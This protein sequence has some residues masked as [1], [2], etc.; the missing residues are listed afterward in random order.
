MSATPASGERAALRGYRWQYDHIAAR[1]YDALLDGDFKSLRLTDPDAGRVDDLVL[2]R[3][4]RADGY[5]FKSAAFNRYLTFRQ[6][7]TDQRT[8]SGNRAPSLLHSLADGWKGLQNQHGDTHVHLV[9]QD[10]ASITDHLGDTGS[11]DQPSPDHFSALITRVLEPL[12]QG[13]TTFG[14]I[15]KGWRPALTRLERASGLEREDFEQ[16]LRFLYLDT[17]AGPGIPLS[18]STRQS[19][20]VALSTALFRCVSEAAGVVVLEERDVLSLMGWLNRPRLHSRHEFP[21]NLDTYQPLAAAIEQL[22]ELTVRHHMGYVAVIGP[23]GSGK[24]TLLSQALTGTVD[25][26]VR[27][28]AYVPGTATAR[29]RLTATTFLHD[30]V[31][32]LNA[33]GLTASERRLPSEDVH[34]LRQQLADQL[35]AAGAEFLEK[36]HRTIIVV[37]GL[38]HVD[39]DYSGSDGLLAE[40]PGPDAI[41]DGVLF[42]VG[43][44]TLTPLHASVRQQIADR[45]ATVDLQHH[46]LSPASI[47]EIC[48]RA[49]VTA[50]LSAEIHQ[51]IVHLSAGHPLALSY[52]LN[53]LRDADGTSA[54]DE[55]ATAPAYEGDVAAQYRAVWD[56]IEDD[57]KIVNIL[58]VCSRLRIGFTTEWLASWASDSAVRTFRR[59]L[60]YL[61]RRQHDEWR[62]FHD[63]F[64]QFAADRTALGDDDRPDEY[65]DAR[66]HQRIAELCA[67]TNDPKIAS[68]RLYHLYY[69]NQRDDALNSATHPT[70]REQYQRLRSPHLIREDIVL[71]LDIAAGRGDV[72]A[73]LRL[74]LAL[75]ELTQRTSFLE[76]VDM[77]GL[78]YSAGLA[79]EAVAWCGGDTRRVPLAHAYEL[80]ARLDAAG[81]PAGR[82]IFDLTEHD[83]LD[84]PNRTRVSGEEDAAAVAWTRAAALF[85]PLPTVVAAIQDLVEA[86]SENHPRDR[87]MQTERWRRY[88]RMT[89]VLIDSVARRSDESALETIDSA[90]AKQAAQLNKHRPQSKETNDRDS[91]DNAR[92]VAIPTVID[93]RVRSQTALLELTTTAEV[94]KPR[95]SQLLS[96]LSGVPLF[97]QTMLNCAEILVRHGMVGQAAG[98]LNRTHYGAALTVKALGHDA[99]P[100]AIDRHFRYW[101]LRYLLASSDDEVPE[102]V[103]PAK[104]TPAGNKIVPDAPVHRDVDAIELA[105]RIDAAVRTLARLDA[106]AFSGHA[107][108]LSDAWATL[109]P[110]LDVFRPTARR[111]SSSRH[112]ITQ[113]KSELM[114]VI[115]NV[116]R[117]YG[118]D[119]PQRLSDM[120][121][122]RFKAQP[123]QWPLPLRLDLADCLRS[124]DASVPWY[125]ETL[126]HLEASV[127]SEDLYSRLDVMADLIRRYA[128]DGERRTARQLVN[129]L[130]PMAFGVGYRK[131]YQFDSWVSWLEQA[132]AE[133]DGGHFVDEAAWLARVLAAA[134]PMTEGAPGTAA[135]DLPAAVVPVSPIAAVRIFE[136]LVRRGT[137]DHLDAFAAL[138]RALVSRV[139]VDGIETV[140]LA[141]DI[142]ADLLARAGTRAYGDLA[143]ALVAAAKRASGSTE[144]ALLA[145]S[146]AS[147]TDICALP[148]TRTGWRQDLGLTNSPTK[149]Q[150]S[151][152]TRAPDDQNDPLVLS[153]GQR[154]AYSDVASRIRTVDD[155]VTL[156]RKEAT[157]SSFSWRSFIDRQRL[158]TSNLHAL[159]QAFNDKSRSSLEVL[160]TL[161]EAAERN[162]DRATALHLAHDILQ[163]APGDS[164]SR[165]YGGLRQHA[166][167]IAARL[168][169]E[170][171]RV[172]ACRNLAHQL[173]V[174]RWLPGL[175]L[176]E[177]HC[178][179]KALDPG[180][181]ASAIWPEIRTYL[182]GMAE[183]LDLPDPD[184][185]TDHGCRWW[186]PAP[187]GDR[188]AASDDSTPAAALAELAVGH[189]SHPTWVVRDG[190]TTIVARALNAGNE[191]VAKALGR[192]AQADASDD[193]LERA[194][195]CLAAAG[196]RDGYSLPNVLQP[197]ERILESHPSQ[198][199][200][201]LVADRS[202]RV[203]RP[204]SPLYRLTLPA[205]VDSLVGSEPVFLFPHEWQYKLLA[206]CLDLDSDTLLAVAARYASEALAV[207]PEQKAVQNALDA[208]QVRH[209]YSTE[210]IAASRAAFGRVLADLNDASLLDDAPPRVRRLLRT[211]DVGILGRVPEARPS[212]VPNP[213]PAGHDQTISRWR[214]DV[215][216][217]LEEYIASSTHQDRVLIG[218]SSRLTV[219]NW[220][221][222]EEE[223][224]C[225]TTVGTS[226]P[227][228]GRIFARQRST[229]LRELVSTPAVH[230]PKS[231]EPLV[232]EN[233]SHTFHQLH[234]DWMSFRPDLAAALAW[235]PDSTRPGCWHTANGELAVEAIWWMDGWWGNADR[236][237]DDTVAEGHA[238]ILTLPGLADIADKFGTITRHFELTRLGRDDGVEVEPVS[239]SR[240]LP[241]IVATA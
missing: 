168:G 74:L 12:R 72:L 99:E 98:L 133:P 42:V 39:R 180:L 59:K 198:V 190:A 204:L 139:G 232:V 145:K 217:R 100:S 155:I 177:M 58:A 33:T 30:I 114:A 136:Y 210:K 18:P 63:S 55:L 184:A 106:A 109:V 21:V 10:L 187:T 73:M 37:D 26:V 230:W 212:V 224:L 57:D 151:E 13:K 200:R 93:L 28:Y 194:G 193:I 167:A 66:V 116:V 51:R 117:S 76:N 216:G 158:P 205:P 188:R 173:G 142:A 86:H 45:Q 36:R 122:R 62:F 225:G 48:R 157:N 11:A 15:E 179:V 103:P 56:K 218:A 239:A 126:V 124:A 88:S 169:G 172:E 47:L 176:D 3:R 197:L 152:K 233:Y 143:T 228:D 219:L 107:V 165:H 137:V 211:V 195:R 92:N 108:P 54:Q 102:S 65:L 220:G 222:L 129:A 206:E 68:E 27:Y 111:S 125:R 9:T 94:A 209:A 234:A 2:I 5:Q 87:H 213:P 23:P 22:K 90:L 95:L 164:W 29:A 24:S 35:D 84:D 241:D 104:D 19:D 191:K 89:K 80:A 132:L 60:R 159:I 183:S 186:L 115:V 53:R 17:G 113:K 25:R 146:L 154:I 81:N 78:L 40:L 236:A 7:I 127:A 134:E 46:R 77:P 135:A 105:A 44:R 166:A 79:D 140:R 231:G 16:F 147:R 123:E 34:T 202:P 97:H 238:V 14:D 110:L 82:R 192:L 235:T 160:D 128:S 138:V 196:S 85:R 199:L 118:A 162:G 223:L 6:V 203:Y 182:D 141:G 119:L 149:H 96:T 227:V 189:L 174:N 38:D 20:I 52:L 221:H 67:E 207:L 185:L 153:D 50:D 75:V 64:R 101:R 208:S 61:F 71:A 83:G 8:R 163:S 148:T 229:I 69:A 178:V 1:V 131:D 144:A 31:V 175:L 4:G 237:F 215:D 171:A 181:R 214:A 32:M 41:P 156:R 49:P 240:S 170:D 150:D 120:L 43:S 201:D 112:G 226:H 130:I 121:T 91:D 70:F 161:A